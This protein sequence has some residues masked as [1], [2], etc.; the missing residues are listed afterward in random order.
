MHAINSLCRRHT[1][2][3]VFYILFLVAA[4]HAEQIW[5]TSSISSSF[6]SSSSSSS[7]ESGSTSSSS[8]PWSFLDSGS[9]DFASSSASAID[10]EEKALLKAEAEA[11]CDLYQSIKPRSWFADPCVEFPDTPPCEEEYLFS[12]LTC[13]EYNHVWKISLASE[14][15][16][17]GTVPAS[18][19][20]LSHLSYLQLSGERLN[21][22][23]PESLTKLRNL[24]TFELSYNQ[25]TGEIPCFQN[26]TRVSRFH[27]PSNYLSGTLPPCFSQMS[28]LASLSLSRNYLSGYLPVI[29]SNLHVIDLAHNNF[30]G[31]LIEHLSI[32]N[33]SK[34][35][36]LTVTNNSFGGTIPSSLTSLSTL[37]ILELSRN[38]FTGTLPAE[39]FGMKL[40]TIFL[41]DNLLSGSLPVCQFST[42]IAYLKLSGN[43]LADTVFVPLQ[44]ASQLLRYLSRNLLTGTLPYYNLLK[45]SLLDLSFNN[46]SGTIPDS[47]WENGQ[48]LSTI[49]MSHNFLSGTLEKFNLTRTYELDM[50]YNFFTGSPLSLGRV[51]VCNLEENCMNCTNITTCGCNN[52]R[53]SNECSLSSPSSFSLL[54]LSSV[55]TPTSSSP[56]TVL[57]FILPIIT[58]VLHIL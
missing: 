52:T 34:L 5:S 37:Q 16:R 25:L 56:T 45:V 35:L 12:G 4:F 53:P 33:F 11:I 41:E 2:P 27:L 30:T 49:K 46:L 47:F 44:R 55:S 50:S 7:R 57:W 15:T 38:R 39:L 51:V 14:S 24:S 1:A 10:P 26:L 36:S 21:G 31:P 3:T 18:L 20:N 8:S 6:S 23:I 54:P 9:S 13:D 29:P 43:Q 48:R 32:S 28:V 22:T 40:L 58:T 19:G 42:S 17:Q